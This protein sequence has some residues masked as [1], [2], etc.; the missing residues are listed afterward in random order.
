MFEAIKAM[1][2]SPERTAKY[3]EM[4]KY[5]V[6]KC[7]WIFS[8]YPV[9]YRL[10]HGWLENY[11]PHN[12]C[13]SRWKYLSLDPKRRRAAKASFTPLSFSDLSAS[14]KQ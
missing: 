3:A 1:P 9:S 11:V 10:T 5:L 13:F 14:L 4:A 2:D 12:F 7:P 8:D 6:S